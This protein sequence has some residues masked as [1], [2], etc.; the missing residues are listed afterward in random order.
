MHL[1]LF[2]FWFGG[3]I[4]KA[5]D[6]LEVFT[7]AQINSPTPAMNRLMVVVNSLCWPFA[8]CVQLLLIAIRLWDSHCWSKQNEC[9][10]QDLA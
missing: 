9:K 10:D 3:F 6:E 5:V 2:W 4:V 7:D 1:F 8:V